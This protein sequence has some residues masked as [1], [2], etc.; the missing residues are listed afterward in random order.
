MIIVVGSG[1]AGVSAAQ[2]LLDQGLAVTMLDAG[3]ELEP[4]FARRVAALRTVEP[5]LWKGE[6]VEFLRNNVA[7]DHKGIGVKHAYGSDFPYRH[8]ERIATIT[9]ANASTG[10]SLARG[11]LSNVWGASILP[12][13]QKDIGDWPITLK[14]LEPHYRAV[15]TGMGV[16]GREDGLAKVFPLYTDAPRPLRAS[17]QGAGLLAA[18]EA[19]RDELERAGVYFGAARLAARAEAREGRSGCVY[20]GL[21]MYGCP[22]ELIYNSAATLDEL[23]RNP[24]FSYEP[25]VVVGRVEERGPQVR[26]FATA[27]ETGEPRTFS[28]ERVY[29]ACGPI[30]TTRV[31]LESLGA[32]DTPVRMLDSCYFLM[33]FLRYRAVKDVAGEQLHTMAQVFIE[34]LDPEVSP[35]TV[36]L[37]VYTY[38][39]MYEA[40]V[41]GLLGPLAGLAAPLANAAISRLL[42][43]LCYLHSDFSPG[44]SL[45][46]G[47]DDAA[48]SGR[49]LAIEGERLGDITR[50]SIARVTKK[51]SGCRKA[52]R[53]RP[54]GLLTHITAPGR[55]YHSG[56][57]FPM[58]ATPGPMQCDVLGRPTGFQRVHAVDAT[59]F[60]SIP[61]TTITLSVMANAH[62]IASRYNDA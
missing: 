4:E 16:S 27:V 21:C 31:L 58:Q 28:A 61:A 2:A 49:V 62:R 20:C 19:R 15:L 30:A 55:G 48:P 60:P 52:L 23:R 11:G 3:Q 56:G 1:P 43:A 13:R 41:R 53:A 47:R 9:R 17:R 34:I 25:G 46:L 38:N 57:T 54:V 37:Q 29:L 14:D 33:P 39:D 40:G 12:C 18:M 32:F 6:R 42:V 51:L 35:H 45:T 26:L 8:E 59:V 7:P 36:H 50:R 10:P 24:S 22:H 44:M 5:R